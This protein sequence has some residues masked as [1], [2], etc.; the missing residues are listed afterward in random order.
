[1][2]NHEDTDLFGLAE[3]MGLLRLAP[4]L[5]DC[6]LDMLRMG[7]MNPSEEKLVLPRLTSLKFGAAVQMD[8]IDGDDHLLEHLSLPAL[9]ELSLPFCTIRSPEFL[10]FLQRSSPPLQKLGFGAGSYRFSFAELD[11]WLRIVP[12]LTH[13]DLYTEQE[14]FVEVVFSALADLS[15]LG[16]FLPNLQS[17]RIQQGF[18]GLSE[19]ACQAASRALSARRSQLVCVQVKSLHS[20][21]S[22]PSAEVVETLRQLATDGMDIYLGDWQ[23][24]FIL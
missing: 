11:T 24:N 19:S 7:D 21:S 14:T 16:D 17:L 6:T 15:S 18:R 5:A 3:V 8:N 20:P 4:N 1:M 2:V 13:L 9:Q 23:T 12:S 22:K 10:L